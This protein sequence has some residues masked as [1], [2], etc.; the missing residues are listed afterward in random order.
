MHHCSKY[1][2]IY[3]TFFDSASR[4]CLDETHGGLRFMFLQMVHCRTAMNISGVYNGIAPNNSY[5]V[6][7]YALLIPAEVPFL[8]PSLPSSKGGGRYNLLSNQR[9]NSERYENDISE[10]HHQS[11]TSRGR[12]GDHPERQ[13]WA[14]PSGRKLPRRQME[15]IVVAGTHNI[16]VSLQRT[17]EWLCA[18]H[19]VLGLPS[20][21]GFLRKL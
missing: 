3:F 18:Q 7:Q 10:L 5:G 14:D 13:G 19:I 16:Q 2:N 9:P 8:D 21:L 1:T 17:H 11:P 6:E 15:Y 20:G 12:S 4:V